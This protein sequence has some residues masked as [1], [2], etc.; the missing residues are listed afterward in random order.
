[1]DDDERVKRC[2]VDGWKVDEWK[3]DWWWMG[4]GG[5]VVDRGTVERVE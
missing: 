4:G 1:M 2:V 3:V 5:W